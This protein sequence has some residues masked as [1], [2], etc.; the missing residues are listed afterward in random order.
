MKLVEELSEVAE[1]M[2]KRAERKAS[3]AEDLNDQLAGELADM[4]HYIAAVAALNGIDLGETILSKDRKAAVKY[5]HD[6]KL[7]TFIRKRNA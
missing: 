4:I 1:V 5:H 2:N 7:E 3:D 6:T